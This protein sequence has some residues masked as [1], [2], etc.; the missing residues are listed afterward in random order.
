VSKESIAEGCPDCGCSLD[1]C[2][3]LDKRKVVLISELKKK[4]ELI[5]DNYQFF[6]LK[7]VLWKELGLSEKAVVKNE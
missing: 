2:C 4:V 6:G 7:K 5:E 1:I 3:G